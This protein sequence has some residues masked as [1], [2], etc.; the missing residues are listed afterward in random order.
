MVGIW[1]SPDISSLGILT[2]FGAL[3]EA[4]KPK[5]QKMTNQIVLAETMST[6]HVHPLVAG[7]RVHVATHHSE[8]HTVS[9]QA[10]QWK[11]LAGG[12][13][14]AF[15]QCQSSSLWGAEGLQQQGAAQA[16]PHWKVFSWGG[17]C[18]AAGRQRDTTQLIAV[19]MGRHGV[20]EQRACMVHTLIHNPTLQAGLYS[21]KSCLTNY[22]AIYTGARVA[23]HVC[24]LNVT[25]SSV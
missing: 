1:H 22:T 20:G 3:T 8:K 2:G 24:A 17:K 23:T 4:Q 10:C 13:V 5:S 6:L 16:F 18:L 19:Q 21:P 11:I 9:T 15:P 25:K 12:K 7:C 14:S